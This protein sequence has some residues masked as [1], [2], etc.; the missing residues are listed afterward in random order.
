M[1]EFETRIPRYLNSLPQLLWWEIDEVLVLAAIIG[2][3]IVYELLLLTVPL[4]LL[5]VKGMITLKAEKQAGFLIH[6]LWWHQVPIA[7]LTVPS[8]H[9]EFWE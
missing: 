1:H 2:L 9:R 8:T 5:L 7:R 3:G 4:G 6:W